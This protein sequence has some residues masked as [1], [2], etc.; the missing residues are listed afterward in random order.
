ML[1]FKALLHNDIKHNTITCT[2]TFAVAFRPMHGMKVNAIRDPWDLSDSL[3]V[4]NS[5]LFGCLYI[6]I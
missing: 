6:F 3:E 2:E 4:E 1:S 5:H